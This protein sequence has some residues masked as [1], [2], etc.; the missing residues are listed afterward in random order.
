M[1]TT[2]AFYWEHVVS[3]DSGIISPPLKLYCILHSPIV[4]YLTQQVPRA[5]EWRNI[6]KS[7]L[8]TMRQLASPS[9]VPFP[10]RRTN[11][12]LCWLA[13]GSK[14]HC[15]VRVVVY[16]SY[17]LWSFTQPNVQHHHPFYW[18]YIP[19]YQIKLIAL[20]LSI[21]TSSANNHPLDSVSSVIPDLKQAD[22]SP[23]D[24]CLESQKRRRDSGSRVNASISTLSLVQLIHYIVDRIPTVF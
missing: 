24:R 4:W 19:T 9:D 5:R 13:N 14:N 3:C 12:V 15:D 11:T 21:V 2:S 18:F 16:C 20:S 8:G 1:H 6:P 7:E 17:M 10:P 23:R 22:W